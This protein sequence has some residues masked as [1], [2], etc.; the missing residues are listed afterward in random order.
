MKISIKPG[1]DFDYAPLRV[2]ASH[3]K[4]G[5]TIACKVASE[6]ALDNHSGFWACRYAL[7]EKAIE[8]DVKD[9]VFG[10][11]LVDH[12]RRR[13]SATFKAK[14]NKLARVLPPVQQKTRQKRQRRM[15]MRR[16]E[17][18]I[19]C[20]T[21]YVQPFIIIRNNLPIPISYCIV[22]EDT[23]DEKRQ[24][25]KSRQNCRAIG[26]LTA[27]S[28]LE[29]TDVDPRRALSL[30]L[31]VMGYKPSRKVPIHGGDKPIEMQTMPIELTPLLSKDF[32]SRPKRSQDEVSL[33]AALDS[34]MLDLPANRYKV[35]LRMHFESQFEIAL[36]CPVW[37]RNKTQGLCLN[38][39]VGNTTISHPPLSERS[40]L[41]KPSSLA[42][43]RFRNIG[44]A[45][46]SLRSG[47]D[48]IFASVVRAAVV[49]KKQKRK[50]TRSISLGL[51]TNHLERGDAFDVDVEATIEDVISSLPSSYCAKEKTHLL[52][53]RENI[54]ECEFTSDLNLSH[55][56]MF[57]GGNNYVWL[58]VP[59]NES[60]SALGS[61]IRKLC[62]VHKDEHLSFL[63]HLIHATKFVRTDAPLPGEMPSRKQGRK[64][65]AA[66]AGSS[67]RR[68]SLLPF[69]APSRTISGRNSTTHRHVS[70]ILRRSASWFSASS[71]IDD[72]LRRIQS[73][74]QADA[75]EHLE[76]IMFPFSRKENII[77][78]VK[79]PGYKRSKPIDIRAVAARHRLEQK[80]FNFSF[81]EEKASRG[82]GEFRKGHNVVLHYAKGLGST[83][84]LTFAPRYLIRSCLSQTVEWA[85]SACK[86]IQ[87]HSISSH[88]PAVPIVW[89]NHKEKSRI[90]I[91]F[92]EDTGWR[93]SEDIDLESI[94]NQL[95]AST[96][97]GEEE[98]N[99][100]YPI[101]MVRYLGGGEIAVTIVRISLHISPFGGTVITL[102]SQDG[103]A[104]PYR[105]RNYTNRKI[106]F[107]QTG[108]AAQCW[109]MC[110]P[111][112]VVEYMWD[113]SGVG[114]SDDS[115]L[116]GISQMPRVGDRLQ[117]KLMVRCSGDSETG[118]SKT[119]RQ[120]A[121][122]DISEH[123]PL[124]L[125]K[126]LPKAAYFDSD[127]IQKGIILK[128]AGP[129]NSVYKKR[130]FC[131]KGAMLYYFRCE[132]DSRDPE[133]C[134][135][136]INIK[137]A[138]FVG[139]GD[140]A[141]GRKI[142][143]PRLNKLL[144]NNRAKS[145]R[146]KRGEG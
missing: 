40:R 82:P 146:L 62:I 3:A 89:H 6:E 19:V 80:S 130:F 33:N 127:D 120:F 128:R 59:L 25:H 100:S 72:L 13:S 139:P 116:M 102:E 23:E 36:T 97:A 138:E 76:W 137:M 118:D 117:K 83:H 143:R 84:M 134:L 101:K 16:M 45:V 49:E 131:L 129:F 78:T 35:S 93:W 17:N 88:A 47:S 111:H 74:L 30:I 106:W 10:D 55:S 63:S 48:R 121:L 22:D 91:R 2:L 133:A 108:K 51:P 140:R 141:D 136:A 18:K 112:G 125:G 12:A 98:K 144:R 96:K 77:F 42:K 69:S 115:G 53:I 27:E 113:T 87:K 135:G 24:K 90:C 43:R 28:S 21:L 50:E 15:H 20:T 44:R 52:C 103:C 119:I 4:R 71:N 38:Y 56:N 75:S 60:L 7:R 105:I 1:D 109:E 29:L 70:N 67:K 41:A 54:S 122:D 86:N 9:I 57:M 46:T 142:R 37:A 114:V 94:C 95:H 58:A 124:W 123:K 31:A 85:Q 5:R 126:T 79:V 32:A 107:K 68:K 66:T 39:T 99:Q 92:C 81:K 61:S 64:S 73:R 110:P 34:G 26:V 65:R 145:T 132:E 8:C 14:V 104:P 11:G